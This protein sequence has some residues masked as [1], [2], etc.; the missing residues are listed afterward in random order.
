MDFD[1]T[2][3]RLLSLFRISVIIMHSTVVTTIRA[4]SLKKISC[5]VLGKALSFILRFSHV[6][7]GIFK[8][9]TWSLNV[10]HE[11][12]TLDIGCY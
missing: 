2:L 8:F 5:P 4:W 3:Y 12:A 7:I 9:Y 10:M 6:V 11:S 1:E